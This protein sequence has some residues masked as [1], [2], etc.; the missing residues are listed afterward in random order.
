MST[1]VAV[2]GPGNIGT[3]LMV[4]ILRLS[5]PIR[6]ALQPQAA[7]DGAPSAARRLLPHR[8]PPAPLPCQGGRQRVGKRG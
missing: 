3:R 6:D 2:I 5:D 4:K 1:K 7:P 8:G